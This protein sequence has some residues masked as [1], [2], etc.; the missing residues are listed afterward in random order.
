MFPPEVDPH[1][2]STIAV[3][4]IVRL[5]AIP[6]AYT[7]SGSTPDGSTE[8]VLRSV[9]VESGAAGSEVVVDVAPVAVVV[10]V[11]VAAVWLVGRCV[12]DGEAGDDDL[13][14]TTDFDPAVTEQAVTTTSNATTT[15]RLAAARPQRET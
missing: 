5:E 14:A 3:G 12:V 9:G 15:S 1:Q 4:S 2:W 6:P 10:V 13:E 7:A 11:V 8:G